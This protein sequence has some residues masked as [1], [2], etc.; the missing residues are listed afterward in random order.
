MGQVKLGGEMKQSPRAAK[1]ETA[2]DLAEDIVAISAVFRRVECWIWCAVRYEAIPNQVE[3]ISAPQFGDVFLIE[4]AD[5]HASWAPVGTSGLFAVEDLQRATDDVR[6]EITRLRRKT[7]PAARFVVQK[8]RIGRSAENVSS[9]V[10]RKSNFGRFNAEQLGRRLPE[11]DREGNRPALLEPGC[12]L[13]F[14]YIGSRFVGQSQTGANGKRAIGS[15]A[16]RTGSQQRLMR[17]TSLDA[18]ATA[19]QADRIAI[20]LRSGVAVEH[21]SVRRRPPTAASGVEQRTPAGSGG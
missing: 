12:W 2:L 14:K 3:R 6:K 4:I 10:R 20:T 5:K 9:L 17:D 11:C 8:H 18:G 16:V 21:C 15:V 19:G 7:G 1:L 13:E